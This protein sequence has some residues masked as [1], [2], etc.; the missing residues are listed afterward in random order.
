MKKNLKELRNEM[1]VVFAVTNTIWIV[2]ITMLGFHANLSVFHTNALGFAFLAVYGLIF[3]VQFIALIWHR[4]I[5]VRHY[6]AHQ[7]HSSSKMPLAFDMGRDDVDDLPDAEDSGFR[8]PPTIANHQHDDG[9]VRQP[10][11]RNPS[12]STTRG[13]TQCNSGY[14]T[15]LTTFGETTSGES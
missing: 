10:L 9:R 13:Q 12:T 1:V 8:F 6:L 4:I 14:G 5:T 15:L 7:D 11:R 3:F 2:L